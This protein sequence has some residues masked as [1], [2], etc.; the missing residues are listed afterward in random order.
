MAA[1]TQYKC[2]L[3]EM[4]AHTSRQARSLYAALGSITLTNVQLVG[5]PWLLLSFSVDPRPEYDLSSA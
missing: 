4:S 2:S 3:R 5:M 1:I